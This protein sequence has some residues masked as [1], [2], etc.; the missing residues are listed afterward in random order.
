[1]TWVGVE[2]NNLHLPVPDDLLE[3]AKRKAKET[4]ETF[5]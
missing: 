5:E 4:L 2:S 1:M 3:E